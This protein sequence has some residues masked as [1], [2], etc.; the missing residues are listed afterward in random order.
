ML[1]WL[2]QQRCRADWRL[3]NPPIKGDLCINPQWRNIRQYSLCEAS[4]VA[5][6]AIAPNSSAVA[7][8]RSATLAA[9]NRKPQRAEA[10][11]LCDE[12]RD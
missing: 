7:M 8:A 4:S 9:K 6:F 5:R 3:R 11:R 1:I 12:V 2:V 10:F